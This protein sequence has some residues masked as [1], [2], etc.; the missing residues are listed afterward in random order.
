M[1][2]LLKVRLKKSRLW[3]T[4]FLPFHQISILPAQSGSRIFPTHPLSPSLPQT[5]Q[6]FSQSKLVNPLVSVIFMSTV[7]LKYLQYSPVRRHPA[8]GRM[9][10]PLL[11]QSPPKQRHARQKRM[12]ISD[13]PKNMFG[14]LKYLTF[15]SKFCNL[16]LKKQTTSCCCD[17]DLRVLLHV[18]F[19]HV[20]MKTTG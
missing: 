14:S 11:I 5:H 17:A 16:N 1:E 4:P 13:G 12:N 15:K 8:R 7:P 3:V 18:V 6:D 19:Q 10:H 2:E 20:K 9:I